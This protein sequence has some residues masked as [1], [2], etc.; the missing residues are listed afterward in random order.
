ADLLESVFRG[1]SPEESGGD[2]KAQLVARLDDVAA[3]LEKE[4][5]GEPLVRARLR[6]TLGLT[7]ADLGEYAKAVALHR[8]AVE[9]V[10]AHFGPAHRETLTCLGNLATSYH[11]AGRLS[12]ALPLYEQVLAGRKAQLGP[13]H[14]DTLVSMANLAAAYHQT[15]RR[16][17]ALRL[18]EQVL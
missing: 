15:D 6:N 5:A 12:E 7:L 1:L 11:H 10:R 2:L 17:E 4:H 14:P 3:K 18:E 13:E 9:E 8:Q 16:D